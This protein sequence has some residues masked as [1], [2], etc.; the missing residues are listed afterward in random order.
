MECETAATCIL[1]EVLVPIAHGKLE[2]CARKTV[3]FRQTSD[4]GAW[5][6]VLASTRTNGNS[7][8]SSRRHSEGAWVQFGVHAC[9]IQSSV[10]GCRSLP[11]NPSA[12]K[13]FGGQTVGTSVFHPS[14]GGK[15]LKLSPSP[16]VSLKLGWDWDWTPRVSTRNTPVA[17]SDVGW[18]GSRRTG[19]ARD[20]LRFIRLPGSSLGNGD[21]RITDL[22]WRAP[23]DSRIPTYPIAS[24]KNIPNKSMK[25]T[26]RK[27]PL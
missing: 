18:F 14:S 21:I 26:L 19:Q 23:K 25:Q 10:A 13:P 5:V 16:M 15:L 27:L 17:P 9:Q 7:I 3:G 4:Q 8:I 12:A 22:I 20:S 6:K 11:S 24:L 2:K 1:Y